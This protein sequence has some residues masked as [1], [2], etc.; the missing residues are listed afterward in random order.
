MFSASSA[1][2]E[3]AIRTCLDVTERIRLVSTKVMFLSRFVV[4][5]VVSSTTQKLRKIL[6]RFFG[7]KNGRLEFRGDLYVCM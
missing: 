5:S 2:Q 1:G 3:I 4:L 7:T 6:L